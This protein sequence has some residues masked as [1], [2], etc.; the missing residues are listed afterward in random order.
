MDRLADTAPAALVMLLALGFT[1]AVTM[2]V[3]NILDKHI[4][5]DK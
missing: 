5:K 2:K 3:L 4:N 1:I